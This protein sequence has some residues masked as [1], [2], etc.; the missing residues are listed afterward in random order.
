M[1]AIVR[2]KG[3]VQSMNKGDLV[4]EKNLNF[5]LL[6]PTGTTTFL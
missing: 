4:H 6:F 5:V 1:K 3:A 2:K